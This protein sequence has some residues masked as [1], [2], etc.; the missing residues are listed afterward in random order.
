MSAYVTLCVW[1]YLAQESMLLEPQVDPTGYED[2]PL[3]EPSAN[4][5][6]APPGKVLSANNEISTL[7]K[8]L[9]ALP[10]ARINFQKFDARTTS[11]KGVIFYLHGNRGNIK[12]CRWEIEPFLDAGYDV[13]TMDYRTFGDSK[14]ALSEAALLADAQMVY[15]FLCTSE[16][17]N[18]QDIVVWG[19]SFGSGVAAHIAACN[20]PQLLVL[21]TPYYS[22]PD[23]VCQS[24]PYLLPFL[25]RYRLPT[26]FFLDYVNCPVHLIH[27]TLDE[28]IPHASS[29]RLQ[30]KHAKAVL[31][32]IEGG[33][34]NL[35]TTEFPKLVEEI[36]QKG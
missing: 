29:E 28:K 22:L 4:K 14:G 24:R 15:R 25:F 21:E 8:D 3:I 5:F 7:P 9:L 16:G 18:E 6:L 26:Y 31:H 19:R 2:R 1:F 11:S 34:H 35:R 23:A 36:L 13:W 12:K 17:V 20:S 30:R 10:E 32:S 27:G 33:D